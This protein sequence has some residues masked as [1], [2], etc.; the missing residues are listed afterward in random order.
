MR[1]YVRVLTCR[2]RAC[3]GD[4]GSVSEC[5]SVTVCARLSFARSC[6]RCARATIGVHAHL[7]TYLCGVNAAEATAY[8]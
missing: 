3:V 2:V 6:T 5:A 7:R 4:D 1:V 8:A